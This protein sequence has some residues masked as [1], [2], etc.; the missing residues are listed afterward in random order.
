MVENTEWNDDTT[1][2]AIRCFVSRSYDDEEVKDNTIPRDT[3]YTIAHTPVNCKVSDKSSS[4][5][6]TIVLKNVR[7]VRIRVWNA[8]KIS[9]YY[10]E[11]QVVINIHFKI[12]SVMW[13]VCIEG[14]VLM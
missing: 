14:N 2:V 13:C 10:F 9:I 11:L 12:G 3:M 6:K 1:R 4:E 8:G 5:T 7:M